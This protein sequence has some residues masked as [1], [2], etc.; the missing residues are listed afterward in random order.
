MVTISSHG[1]STAGGIYI[2]ECS[3]GGIIESVAYQWLDW[4][5]NP[6]TN[7]SLISITNSTSASYLQFS[8]LHKSHEGNYTCNASTTDDTESASFNVSVNGNY[9]LFY[10]K[11]INY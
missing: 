11:N 1:A 7:G 2:L 6:V 4:E 5:G 8:P 3:V 10:Y 9:S